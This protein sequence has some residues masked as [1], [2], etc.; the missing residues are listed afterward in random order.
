MADCQNRAMFYLTARLELCVTTK[1]REPII[2]DRQ[3]TASWIYGI[4]KERS[5]LI[6]DGN[7]ISQNKSMKKLMIL[8]EITLFLML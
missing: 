8:K 3:K 5:K 2:S 4:K 7:L 6:K 1:T